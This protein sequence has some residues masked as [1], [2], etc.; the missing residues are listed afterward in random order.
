MKHVLLIEDDFDVSRTLEDRLSQLGFTSFER[1]WSEDTAVAAALRHRPDLVLV[2]DS[3]ASG[4]A[5]QAAYRIAEAQDVPIVLVA[6]S[7]R[8]MPSD[9]PPTAHLSG[10]YVLGAL[11]DVVT[12]AQSSVPVSSR[13]PAR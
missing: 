2:G 5:I 8:A 12:A 11:A 4:S 6:R 3:I 10:P 1:V 13:A 9:L 7:S